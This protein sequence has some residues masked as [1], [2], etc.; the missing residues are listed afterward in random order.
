MSSHRKGGNKGKDGSFEEG[1]HHDPKR[2][3]AAWSSHDHH[4]LRPPAARPHHQEVAAGLLGD[5]TQDHPRWQAAPR[6][7]LGL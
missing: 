2:R 3:E 1:D 6:D 4:P 5:R 7:D